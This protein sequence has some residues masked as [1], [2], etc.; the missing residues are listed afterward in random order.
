M[1]LTF[2]KIEAFGGLDWNRSSGMFGVKAQLSENEKNE[3]RGRSG[4]EYRQHRKLP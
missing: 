1:A 4:R 2:V 3:K